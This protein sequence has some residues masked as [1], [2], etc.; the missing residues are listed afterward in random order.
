MMPHPRSIRAH[1]FPPLLA[2]VAAVGVAGQW[3]ACRGTLE[4]HLRIYRG[5]AETVIAAAAISVVLN[6]AMIVVLV[7]ATI[8]G[9]L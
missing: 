1:P 8:V 5:V 4:Q 6:V 9:S 2:N 7:M 3:F